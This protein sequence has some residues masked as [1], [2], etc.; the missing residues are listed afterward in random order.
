VHNPLVLSCVRNRPVRS[1]V[2]LLTEA[3]TVTATL[4]AAAP[5]P[6]AE[7]PGPPKTIRVGTQT[8]HRCHL[9]TSRLTYC[10]SVRAPLD[11]TDPSAAHI[12]VGF[13]WVPAPGHP[14]RSLVAEEGG[15]GYPAT[16]SAWDYVGSFGPLLQ[17]R[18][19]LL[20]DER[21]TGRTAVINCQPLQSL[22]A[23]SPRFVAALT[24][25]GKR[26]NHTYHSSHGGYV[27]ASD[28][29]TTAN[30]ARDMARVI[31]ALRLGKV[32]LYG[33]SYGTYF[34]Q[35]FLSRYPHLLRSVVLDS[36]Y[37]ARDLDPWYRTTVTTARR[38]FD[39]VCRRALG[40]PRGSPWARIAMLA[41]RLRGHPVR[42]RVVGTDAKL[43]A[44]QVGITAL[45]NIVNDAGYDTDPY[46]QLDAAT[47]AY[48]ARRD[49]TPLLRLYAQDLG[50][51]YSDYYANPRYY[52]DGSYFA[53]ACTDYPQLFDMRS[54]QRARHQQLRRSIRLL[55]SNTFA[56]F[57]TR[58]WISVL[59]YT[60]TYTGCLHWPTATHPADPPVPH[61]VRLHATHV[62]VLILNG[63]LDSLT[64]AAGGAHIKRQI[65]SAARHVV[66]A[67]EVHLTIEDSAYRCGEHLMHQFVLAPHGR[68]NTACASRIPPIRAVPRF[69][70]T[71][72]DAVP[73]SGHA[74]A[75]LK[76]VASVA[77]AEAGDAAYRFDFVD[78]RRDRGLRGGTVS[79][80]H[81]VAH[82]SG[83]RYVRDA[84][85]S[86]TVNSR[87]DTT[88][89]S[90]VVTGPHRGRHHVVLRYGS[91]RH[92]H[93]RI[94]HF[95][96]R[97]PAP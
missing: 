69:P 86:G 5:A 97:A 87:G 74:P 75:L 2:A 83:V 93:V 38:A 47:R 59:P 37:E 39:Q 12:R 61:G 42:G 80:R 77:V 50:Y 3:V 19:M 20:V 11:Y 91:V 28:L 13:G 41:H 22:P 29:F 32:D 43:H 51:D 6:A 81:G 4:A 92:A 90:F 64:P 44:V 78:G 45:V 63:E 71:L 25:C 26:L 10:G 76:R 33:D 70:T 84:R 62:P 17:K 57:T 49:A 65:G 14:R 95:T 35:S 85:I 9:G 16:D 67:N 7:R 40:C 58:E 66:V 60:E 53:V 89:A 24:T 34:S 79:Y 31:H 15:P 21:G 55:P 88:K 82:L 94:G 1:L 18:N 46:R 73:A 54:P 30:A 96:L 48:L 56:P 23:P 8:L 27:H 52:S 68:L 72:S 36:A